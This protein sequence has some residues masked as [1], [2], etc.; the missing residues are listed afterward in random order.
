MVA[1]LGSREHE[2]T[3]SSG[4]VGSGTSTV[5]AGAPQVDP[6]PP[7]PDP[8]PPPPAEVAFVGWERG[9]RNGVVDLTYRDGGGAVVT[10]AVFDPRAVI[11]AR[12]GGPMPTAVYRQAATDQIGDLG[13]QAEWRKA[14]PPAAY[15]VAVQRVAAGRVSPDGSMHVEVD[16]RWHWRAG[17][18]PAEVEETERGFRVTWRRGDA[19]GV[20]VEGG[21]IREA[22][23]NGVTFNVVDREGFVWDLVPLGGSLEGSDTPIDA[24]YQDAEFYWGN[25]RVLVVLNESTDVPGLTRGW[26]YVRR[27]GP[28]LKIMYP[29][30]GRDRAYEVADRLELNGLDVT[31][32]EE[33]NGVAP[34]VYYRAL[35]ENQ[36]KTQSIAW[37]VYNLIGDRVGGVASG[38]Q[39]DG[40]KT[41]WSDIFVALP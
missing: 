35:A 24:L 32:I 36:D 7:A 28:Q 19:A 21:P 37:R 14:Q 23:R 6:P 5:R 11:V 4:G 25:D 38:P 9:A 31:T 18:M 29:T 40:S 41:G 15:R 2:A 13:A 10:R 33:F 17:L 26:F 16:A 27:I 34:G 22:D 8:P 1:F 20:P 3:P 39:V 30:G 12:L